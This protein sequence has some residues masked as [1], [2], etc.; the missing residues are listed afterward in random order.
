MDFMV[1]SLYPIIALDDAGADAGVPP[2][3]GGSLG[4]VFGGRWSAVA[5][6][7][8]VGGGDGG[9]EGMWISGGGVN[10]RGLLGSSVMDDMGT[11]WR[12]MVRGCGL[13]TVRLVVWGRIG[14]ADGG[15]GITEYK[16][17]YDVNLSCFDAAPS[18]SLQG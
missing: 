2:G 3:P 15:F 14:S 12:E 17:R 18:R 10:S 9:G 5:G 7:A 11:P 1:L 16:L 13:G 6:R 8:M 4:G